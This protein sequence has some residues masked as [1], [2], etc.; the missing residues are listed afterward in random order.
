MYL[1]FI[2]LVLSYFNVTLGKMVI[3]KKIDVGFELPSL[4]TS[5]LVVNNSNIE[6]NT[7]YL[8]S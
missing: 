8:F 5:L 6:F 7:T 2:Y 1:R 3:K 4:V